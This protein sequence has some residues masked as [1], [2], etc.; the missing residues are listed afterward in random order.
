MDLRRVKLASV[1]ALGA[2][3][4]CSAGGA[5]RYYGVRPDASAKAPQAKVE[6]AEVVDR[7]NRNAE[8][9]QGLTATS[10]V[11]GNFG[12]MGGAVSG[13]MAL[14]RPRNF[15]LELAKP[16][17]GP[18]VD[19]GSNDREF[20]IWSKES[21]EREMYVGQYGATGAVEG[22][23]AFRPEWIVESLGLRVIPAE[24][25][26]R[27][28]VDTRNP[29]YIVLTHFRDD[30]R[31]SSQIKKTV[32]DANTRQVVRHVFYGDDSKQPLAVVTPSDYRPEGKNIAGGVELPHRIQIKL[33]N[34]ANPKDTPTIDLSL[35][36]VKV[37]PEFSDGN[38]QALFEIPTYE[39]Y[40]VVDISGPRNY[41]SRGGPE[42]SRQS[43]PIPASTEVERGTRLSDPVPFGTDGSDLRRNDPIPLDADLGTSA[44]DAISPALVRPQATHRPV[45]EDETLP[46]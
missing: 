30:G 8:P 35:R 16:M 20:W 39:G 21:K 40:R 10:S 36:D 19:L 46:R 42:Q 18:V 33:S 32:V 29:S 6:V 1:V 3:T 43:R 12:R 22:D 23:L 7:I 27:I 25:Q 38:R 37:N 14:E 28:Q 41:A 24:E 34:P 9:V 45:Y 2:L 15:K 44:P 5:N 13:Q 4:G 11:S 17:G 26:A 31:G